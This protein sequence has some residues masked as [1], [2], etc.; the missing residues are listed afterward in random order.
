MPRHLCYSLAPFTGIARLV[1]YGVTALAVCGLAFAQDSPAWKMDALQLKNGARIEGLLIETTATGYRFR[2]VIRKSGSP[3]ITGTEDYSLAEVESVEPLNQADRDELLRKLADLDKQRQLFLA[4]LKQLDQN[5]KPSAIEGLTLKPI[6]WPENAQSKESDPHG[7]AFDSKY[8]E[9]RTDLR[10]PIA[11]LMALQLEEVFRA[12]EHVIPARIQG[13]ATSILVWADRSGFVQ[14]TAKRNAS[15]AHPA[16]FDTAANRIMAGTDLA[17]F[18]A[19][20]FA[21]RTHHAGEL[22]LL[23]QRETEIS[24]AMGGRIPPEFQDQFAK[25]RREIREAEQRNDQ[26]IRQARQHLLQVLNHEAIH[27]YL[28]NWVFP[29]TTQPLPRWLNEGLAQVFETAFIEAGELRANWPDPKRLAAV[30]RLLTENH[31]PPL[32]RT[33]STAT[34]HFLVMTAQAAAEREASREAYLSSWV[35]TY[36]LLFE[37]RLLSGAKLDQYL[38]DL[39]ASRDPIEAFEKWTGEPLDRFEQKLGQWIGKLRP[40]GTTAGDEPPATR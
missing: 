6:F 26:T 31:F 15:L 7:W 24:K 25:S 1:A 3:T 35:L 40:D 36:Y 13:K 28:I 33:L 4:S 38:A 18:E 8:F 2:Q 11:V 22:A 10:E 17:K 12:C 19:E 14:A 39:A 9:L 29:P 30:R 27:A 21:I 37:K 23:S 32:K 16:V 5:G 34:D 20:G